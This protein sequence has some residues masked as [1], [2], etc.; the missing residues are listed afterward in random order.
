M[1]DSEK[2]KSHKFSREEVKDRIARG[3]HPR[4][5]RRM[6]IPLRYHAKSLAN[7]RGYEAEVLGVKASIDDGK[8]AYITGPCGRGK[9]HLAVGLLNFWFAG[10][11]ALQRAEQPRARYLSMTDFFF[12]LRNSFSDSSSSEDMQN[13]VDRYVSCGLLLI[14][15]LGAQ[16]NT[17]WSR[18]VL[19]LLIDR[20][21]REMKP[22]I[23][24]SN[25]SLEQIS[26]LIDDRIASR[27][28]EM[29]PVIR[30]EG[31]DDQRVTAAFSMVH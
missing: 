5:L 11:Y 27:L 6:E 26:E 9:T 16:K 29:G 21:Y 19:Y 31:G 8:G 7:F 12:R 18:E 10:Q 3:L 2:N 25:L 30:L 17:E 14:D 13:I 15:D 23:V 24:T 28:A 1:T 22:T 20:R 4:A